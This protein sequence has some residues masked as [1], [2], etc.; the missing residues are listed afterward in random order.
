MVKSKIGYIYILTSPNSNFIKIG[1]TDF[2]PMK[3]IK[4]IN[5][6]EPYRS[7][8]P[9]TLADFRQVSDWRSVEAS[10]HYS[11]RSKLIKSVR[12][13]KELFGVPLN[14]AKK[15]LKEIKPAQ[16]V[17]KPKIDR[18][19]QDEQYTD[20]LIDLL[21]FTG[22]LNCLDIQ[23]IWTFSLFPRTS[24]GRYF[25]INIGR[26]EVAFVTMPSHDNLR[27]HMIY[28]DELILDIKDVR[29]WVMKH[30]GDI[31]R[32][33]YSSSMPRGVSVGFHASFSETKRFLHLGGVRRAVVAYWHEGLISRKEREKSSPFVRYHHW[34]AIAEIRSRIY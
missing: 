16:I 9:W 11:F 8:G 20:Y 13:Q 10:I 29:R 27:Y 7:L 12:Q 23:G 19:F 15:K 22:L 6:S 2:P 25:T 21:R 26:H 3:R 5:A 32:T 1:G 24:G 14:S 4:E 31:S 28:M 17:G 34:N 33:V 18:M 30:D